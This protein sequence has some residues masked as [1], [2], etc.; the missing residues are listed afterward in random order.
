MEQVRKDLRD[1]DKIK[2]K[3]VR[4]IRKIICY[5]AIFLVVGFAIFVLFQNYVLKSD[6]KP[7]NPPEPTPV[8]EEDE[9]EPVIDNRSMLEILYS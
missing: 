7:S 9:P 5:L 3:R 4:L 8:V 2:M 1:K 6:E